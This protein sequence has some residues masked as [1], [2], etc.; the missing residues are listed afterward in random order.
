[1]GAIRRGV[2]EGF[3]RGS[4]RGSRR[5]WAGVH[6]WAA[7]FRLVT[8]YLGI[9]GLM[10]ADGGQKR[11]EGFTE[12]RS[13]TPREP[14]VNPS[15]TPGEPLK[16]LKEKKDPFMCAYTRCA[17]TRPPLSTSGVHGVDDDGVPGVGEVAEEEGKGVSSPVGT[18]TPF[19]PRR[20]ARS[21][22]LAEARPAGRWWD[23]AMTDEARTALMIALWLVSLALAFASGWVWRS[24]RLAE[25]ERARPTSIADDRSP[26]YQPPTV[27]RVPDVGE[28]RHVSG[29]P[30]GVLLVPDDPPTPWR[31]K[32][33]TTTIPVRG[34]DWE[35]E[36]DWERR[37]GAAQARAT[38]S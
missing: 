13:W 14:L 24:G 17:R 27:L 3:R 38:S 18:R 11:A 9:G 7:A 5:R 37:Q 16:P 29:P 33:Q 22:L 35:S 15:A 32:R 2:H 19:V 10:R 31:P 6:G 36:L 25:A 21:R 28:V 34:S 26:H 20:Q 30:E 4:R 23:G 8:A 12:G 1:M